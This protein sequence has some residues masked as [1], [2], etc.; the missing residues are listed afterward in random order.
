MHHPVVW[1]ESRSRVLVVHAHEDV[2]TTLDI[3]T[4][5][6]ERA[7]LV[8]D[9]SLLGAVLTWLV[10]P[11]EAKGLPSFQRQAVMSGQHLYVVGAA[12]SF[13]ETTKSSHAYSHT[14]TDLL[15]I[16]L[17]TLRIVGK[18]QPGATVI[19]A[20]PAGGYLLG[21][22]RATVGQ[23]SE[24]TTPE[25]EEYTGLLVIDPNTLEVVAHHDLAN[26]HSQYEVQ[27]SPTEEV[28][29]LQGPDGSILMFDPT[30]GSVNTTGKTGFEPALLRNSLRYESPSN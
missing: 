11:A 20:S 1:D 3:P 13:E 7:S 26:L 23:V 8:E 2:I 4:G 16:N 14:A 21:S 5:E 24:N 15:K 27:L 29:Y 17:D 25:S 28:I 9:R 19:A 6:M 12:L 30:S 22:G 10:P 18:A